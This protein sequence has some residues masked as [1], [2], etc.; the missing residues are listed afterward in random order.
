VSEAVFRLFEGLPR[1]GPGSDGCTLEALRRLPAL[2]P[3]PRVL[4]LG[5]GAGRSSLVL[6]E[7]LRARVVAVDSHQAFLDQLRATAEERGLDHLIEP[8]CAD[9]ATPGLPAGGV[10]LLWSEGAIYFLGF[11]EGLRLWRP[12]LAPGGCLAVTECSWLSAD[13]PAEAAAFFAEGYPGMAGIEENVLRA[14]AAGFEVLDHFTLPP[15][16]WWDEYYTPLQEHMARLEP[17]A[18]P[19]LVAAIAET[20]RE[21]ELFRR[22]GDAYG[23]VFYLMRPAGRERRLRAGASLAMPRALQPADRHLREEG[24]TEETACS[25]LPVQCG[26]GPARG[27]AARRRVLALPTCRSRWRRQFDRA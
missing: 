2:P 15:K 6:A 5:C 3:T 17:D 7:A 14:R 4:D 9:M 10:D 18:G 13:P 19:D 12:L 25:R 21:I 20:R 1:Q 24:T 8:R 23:Y 22:Y 16:A 27:L 26:P 11:E